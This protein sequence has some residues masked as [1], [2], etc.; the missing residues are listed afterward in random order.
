MKKSE[1]TSSADIV[2]EKSKEFLEYLKKVVKDI[3]AFEKKVNEES[4]IVPVSPEEQKALDSVNLK[5]GKG[6]KAGALQLLDS[7]YAKGVIPSVRYYQI[8][9]SITSIDMTSFFH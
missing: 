3:I 2:K 8:K 1:S 7:Y 5:L 4:K 9:N 6:D